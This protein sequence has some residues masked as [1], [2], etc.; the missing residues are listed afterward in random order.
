MKN[1]LD[2][3]VN[4]IKNLLMKF[5]KP[6]PEKEAVPPQEWKV[7]A[8]VENFDT[9]D[10][11]VVSNWEAPMGGMFSKANASV[12][13]NTLCLVLNQT[14]LADGTIKSVGGEVRSLEEFHY[15]TYEFDMRSSSTAPTPTD[16]GSPISGSITGCFS[17][18]TDSITEIDFE[19]EGK[20]ATEKVIHCTTWNTTEKKEHH[21]YKTTGVAPYSAFNHYKYVWTPTEI[22]FYF[23]DELIHTADNVVPSHRAFFMFNH[24]GTDSKNWGGMAITN[25]TRY[26]YVRNFKYTPL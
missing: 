10:K 2:I 7:P 15:G 6:S 23:N 14:K 11:W 18:N 22:R 8:F 13:N 25:V 21:E 19:I 4:F 17:Y 16:Y 1:L 26:M 20:V 24:W 12:K 9:L 3:I 5:T